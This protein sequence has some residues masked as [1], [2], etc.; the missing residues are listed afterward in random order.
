[1]AFWKRTP[2]YLPQDVTPPFDNVTF[3]VKNGIETPP[4]PMWPGVPYPGVGNEQERYQGGW[5]DGDI[6]AEHTPITVAQNY[7]TAGKGYNDWT[8]CGPSRNGPGLWMRD[9]VVNRRQGT[10]NTSYLQ[11]PEDPG[12]G[13]VTQVQGLSTYSAQA[14]QLIERYTTSGVPQQ[15]RR[16]QNRL[17]PARYSG[18]NYSQTTQVQGGRG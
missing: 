17:S 14:G 1:M 5:N 10:D 16:R 4:P 11:N 12:T 9:V 3:R 13:L 6:N 15:T 18:Q 7:V 2:R 8:S